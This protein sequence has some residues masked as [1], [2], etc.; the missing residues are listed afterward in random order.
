MYYKC[1]KV[2][3]KHGGSDIDSPDWIK[4][5]KASINPKNTDDKYFQHEATV[6]LNYEEI[7]WN[8]G[9]ISNIKPF[10]RKTTMMNMRRLEQYQ[11]AFCGAS[12]RLPQSSKISS[13]R[14]SKVTCPVCVWLTESFIS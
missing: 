13:V 1:H 10:T 7:K 8:P 5:K 3:C 14:S 6:A 11:C 4:K 9:R 2:N 12:L